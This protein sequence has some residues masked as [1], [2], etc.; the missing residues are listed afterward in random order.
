[1]GEVGQCFGSGVRPLRQHMRVRDGK[2]TRV[3]EKRRP[4]DKIRIIDG[5]PRNQRIILASP[6]TPERIGERHIAHS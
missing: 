1:M 5:K 6:E 3:G 2:N 4:D